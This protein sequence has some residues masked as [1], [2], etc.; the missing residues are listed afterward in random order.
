[1]KK[2]FKWTLLILIYLFSTVFSQNQ[3]NIILGVDNRYGDEEKT[4]QAFQRILDIINETSE[5]KWQLKVYKNQ[6]DLL[7]GLKKKEVTII[8]MSPLVYSIHKTD[9]PITAIAVSQNKLKKPFYRSVIFAYRKSSVT[10]ID[11]LKGK[12]IAFGSRFSASSF[13]IPVL[14]L[15]KIGFSLNDL[16]YDFL[17]SQ[18]KIVLK[19]MNLEYD[20]GAVREDLLWKLRPGSYRI[21]YKSEPI[22]ESPL[23]IRRDAPLKIK[24]LIKQSLLSFNQKIQ[25]SP[26]L[27]KK[28]ESDFRYGFSFDFSEEMF[29]PLR[30]A[31]KK[32]N[33]KP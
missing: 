15:T 7:E 11:E 23:V 10:S 30:L 12:K 14:Y 21:L 9:A 2:E 4:R 19:C 18:V 31:Y 17:G 22:P 6:T 24:T 25:S 32:I 28:I 29:I 1:M 8:K 3:A 33:L 13:L 5:V 27:Q 26:D 16:Q 20:V